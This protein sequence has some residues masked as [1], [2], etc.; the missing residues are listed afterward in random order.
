MPRYNVIDAV[1]AFLASGDCAVKIDTS[2]YASL[3]SAYFSFYNC[4]RNKRIKGCHLH[5]YKENLYLI[6]D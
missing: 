3:Q 6:K 5:T 1:E 4:I 2:K